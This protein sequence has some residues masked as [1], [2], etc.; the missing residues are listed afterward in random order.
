MQFPSKALFCSGGRGLYTTR[1]GVVKNK[2]VE[3]ILLDT[4]SMVRQDLVQ[5]GGSWK[6]RQWEFGVLIVIQ[7]CTLWQK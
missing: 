7:C 2:K 6:E 1:T 4:G 3:N 5:E